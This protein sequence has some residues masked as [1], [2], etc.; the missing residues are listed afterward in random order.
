MLSFFWSSLVLLGEW[1]NES[2]LSGITFYLILDF[3][4]HSVLYQKTIQSH[5][6]AVYFGVSKL[7]K[8]NDWFFKISKDDKVTWSWLRWLSFHVVTKALLAQLAWTT[9]TS[10]CTTQRDDPCI[11]WVIKR[12]VVFLGRSEQGEKNER[13]KQKRLARGMW[14]LDMIMLP[15]KD[16]MCFLQIWENVMNMIPVPRCWEGAAKLKSPDLFFFT[17][18]TLNG[19]NKG[20][21]SLKLTFKALIFHK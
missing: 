13:E 20:T 2:I 10:F 7:Q 12:S 18:F 11:T 9:S 14:F 15:K 4:P 3:F 6:E 17:F 5:N 16:D 19:G 21:Y 8:N 1:R